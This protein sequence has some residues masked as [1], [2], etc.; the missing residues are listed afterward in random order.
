MS[1][2]NP[3]HVRVDVEQSCAD[4]LKTNGYADIATTIETLQREWKE[5]DNGTRR[6]WWLILAGTPLGENRKVNDLP[7][8]ILK[9]ARRRQGFPPNVPGAIERGPHELAPSIVRQERWGPS[10]KRVL[11]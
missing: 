3:L 6:D 11:K 1:R 2:F 9:A 7:F 5:A 8:P 10:F 4:W